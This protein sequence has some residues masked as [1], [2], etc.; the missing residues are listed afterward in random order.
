M[1][2]SVPRRIYSHAVLI[3]TA[4]VIALHEPSDQFHSEAVAFFEQ[5]PPNWAWFCLR[6]TSHE[7]FTRCRYSDGLEV[8]LSNYDYLRSGSFKLLDFTEADE[9]EAQSLVTRHSDQDYSF[10]DAMCAAVMK[11]VGILNVFTFDSHFW[12]MGFHVWPG[13]TK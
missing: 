3:D 2:G 4:A 6:I 5:C 9:E 12:T 11:R 13:C 7:T 8:A 10:H 1:G